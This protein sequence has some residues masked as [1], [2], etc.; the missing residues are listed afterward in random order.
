MTETQS[1]DPKHLDKY[2]GILSMIQMQLLKMV[3]LSH[4]SLRLM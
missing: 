4:K 1:K 2:Q 3:I